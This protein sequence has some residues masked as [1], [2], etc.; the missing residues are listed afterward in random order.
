[1]LV[2]LLFFHALAIT[3]KILSSLRNITAP[4]SVRLRYCNIKYLFCDILLIFSDIYVTVLTVLIVSLVRL[5]PQLVLNLMLHQSPCLL[6]FSK[7]GENGGPCVGRG[8][9]V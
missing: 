7:P 2:A 9:E 5:S 1:M 3:S 6:L 8:G 4:V